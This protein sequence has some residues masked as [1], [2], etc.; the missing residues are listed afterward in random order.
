M[1]L[2][3][4]GFAMSKS[5][6]RSNNSIFTI[7]LIKDAYDNPRFSSEKVKQEAIENFRDKWYSRCVKN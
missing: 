3:Q 4:G 5:I 1:T 2:R 6:A 7:E